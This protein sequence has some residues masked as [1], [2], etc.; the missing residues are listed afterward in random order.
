MKILNVTDESFRNYGRVLEGYDFTELLDAMN[1][2]PLPEEGC[3]YEPSVAALENCSVFAELRD[4]EYGGLPIQI[5]HCSGYN[6][7]LNALEYHR[8]SE[9]NIAAGS[10]MILLLGKRED[11]EADDTY[12]T[13]KVVA[14]LV[15]EGVAVEL[16]A[17]TLHYAPC[18]AGEEGFRGIVILPRDTN[19]ELEVVPEKKGED[20]L[21]TARNKWLIAHPEAGIE[22]AFCG[23]KGENITL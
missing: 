1:A 23:L 21:I 15:P 2:I 19:L 18:N 17:T 6:H 20:K 11:V 3:V 12:D 8:S 9:V 5:G 16:Y 14:Y 13:S 4:R 22:G 7:V 10:D